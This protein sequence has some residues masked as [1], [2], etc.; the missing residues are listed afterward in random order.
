MLFKRKTNR[1]L[2]GERKDGSTKKQ[3]EVSKKGKNENLQDHWEILKREEEKLAFKSTF[4]AYFASIVLEYKRDDH[5]DDMIIQSTLHK[6]TDTKD[7]CVGNNK[8]TFFNA[9]HF[10]FSL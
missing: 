7:I 1:K 6:Q 8:E 5:E 4:L 2:K 10:T 9:L 3:K